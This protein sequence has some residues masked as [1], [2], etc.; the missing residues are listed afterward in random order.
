MENLSPDYIKTV[1]VIL[2]TLSF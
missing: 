1:K 2:E